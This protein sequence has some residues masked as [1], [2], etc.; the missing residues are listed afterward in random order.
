MRGIRIKNILFELILGVITI[1]AAFLGD[2]MT[3][4]FGEGHEG[5]LRHDGSANITAVFIAGDGEKF[6]KRSCFCDSWTYCCKEESSN[7]WVRVPC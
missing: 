6:G 2:G 4:E 3:A 5:M 7:C 1:S